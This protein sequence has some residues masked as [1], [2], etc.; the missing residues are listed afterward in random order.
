[1]KSC[2]WALIQYDWC[3][4]KRGIWTQRRA[5]GEEDV[6]TRRPCSWSD[7]H[8]PRMTRDGRRSPEARRGL[9]TPCFELLGSTTV[10][11]YTSVASSSQF[12]VL[13]YPRKDDILLGGS[14]LPSCPHQLCLRTSGREGDWNQDLN[15]G[16][17]VSKDHVLN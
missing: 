17:S 2:G 4:Y 6:P 7:M 12:L 5:Q 8:R 11:R 9:L 13:C 14:W 3:L 10:R 15:T 16:P 1:M